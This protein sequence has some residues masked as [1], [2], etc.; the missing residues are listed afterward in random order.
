MYTITANMQEGD[1]GPKVA[2]LYTGLQFLIDKEQFAI[3]GSANLDRLRNQ[4]RSEAPAALYKH[5]D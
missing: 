5:K 2:N 1:T 3:V 4:L